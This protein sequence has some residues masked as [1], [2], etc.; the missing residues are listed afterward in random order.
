MTKTF[1]KYLLHSLLSLVFATG[2]FAGIPRDIFPRLRGNNVHSADVTPALIERM[3]AYRCNALRVNLDMDKGA[4]AGGDPLAPYQKSL[5]N[6]GSVFPACR[7]RG[8]QVILCLSGVPGRRLDVFWNQTADGQNY[9]S[10]IVEIWR[11]LAARY[12]DEP[13]LIGYDILNEPT[14]KSSE[15]DNW[16]KQTLPQSVAAIRESDASIWIVVEPGPWGLPS[17]FEQ[18]PTLDDAR[19]IYSF[20]HY[21]PHAYTHQGVSHVGNASAVDTRGW[22]SYPGD[23]PTFGD[24]TDVKHWNA[25]R[26]EE[27]MKPVI[28]FQKRNP[29]VRILVGEFGV[30][31]W[32]AGNAQWLKD[33][34]DLFEKLGWDW[35]FH[36]L[37]GWNGWDPSVAPDA[38]IDGSQGGGQETDRLAVLKEKWSANVPNTAADAPGTFSLKAAKALAWWET[39]EAVVFKPAKP[40][41][42]AELKALEGQITDGS[43][44]GLKT[45]S[46]S[47]EALLREGWV[48][49]PSEPGFYEI[50]FSWNRASGQKVELKDVFW[51]QAPNG[52]KARFERAAYS[53]A[54]VAPWDAAPKAIGEFGWQYH[55]NQSEIPLAKAVGF[56]FTMI[57]SIPWG[58]HFASLG[59]AIQPA[60]DVYRWDALDADVKALSE[61]G[62]E[63]GGQFCYTPIWASPYPER[64]NKINICV[65]EASA[66][67]PV[68]MDDFT[69]FIE[70]TIARYG[71]TIRTWEIWNEPNL[72]GASCFWSD[73][74]ENYLR[75]Q[76]A[77]Y[78][79]IKRLQPEARVWNGGIADTPSYREFLNR[80]LAGGGGA[81][82]DDLSLHG[83]NVDVEN[84]QAVEKAHQVPFKPVVNSEWHAF[85]IGSFADGKDLPSEEALSLRMMKSAL[86][87]I[88]QGVSMLVIF[89]MTDQVEKEVLPFARENQWFTHC[90]GLFRR[91]PRLEPRHPAVVMAQFLRVTG[92]EA[93]FVKEV[94]LGDD[95]TGIVLQTDHG[96][97]LAFWSEKGP[98]PLERAAIF[99]SGSSI[100]KDWEGK[101]LPIQGQ[102]ELASGKIYYLSAL[103]DTWRTAENADTLD[104]AERIQRQSADAPVASYATGKAEAKWI[105][106]NWKWTPLFADAPK[107]PI[108]AKARVSATEQGLEIEIEVKDAKHVQNEESQWWNGD[109]VQIGIDCEGRGRHGQNAEILAALKPGS[110]VFWKIKNA[111]SGADIPARRSLDNSPIQYGNCEIARK[112]G[113]TAYRL[114]LEWSELYPAV[115]VPGRPLRLSMVVNNNDGA[116]RQGYLEWGG[117]IGG[118]KDP[119]LYG[120]LLPERGASK[121]EEQQSHK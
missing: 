86:L 30:I 83:R 31:R 55:L 64:E 114:F 100:L 3:A 56:D 23:C 22:Y 11:A 69:R 88:K 85:L 29:G 4:E 42:P 10:S 104:P 1:L 61:A 49:H 110:T 15:A 53:V 106:Q 82:F 113:V 18:M 102:K 46:V 103:A 72:P 81:Y 105:D 41:V 97:L 37:G 20:H 107:V 44:K 65:R 9:R 38:P 40:E 62:F 19:V 94:R 21:M 80:V 8:I 96:P 13:A 58:A 26:L 32:A 91:A 98:A 33:S 5:A 79:T 12:K 39:G 27:S 24:G 60:R 117:G 34:I 115:Y 57:H 28:D 14:Y 68:N 75:L 35:T 70:K 54:V 95:A 63:I 74:P 7:A 111:D 2:V 66:Y 71:E 52:A 25:Q 116:G 17:G 78:E 48:W 90:A 77:G 119:S 108:S 47:R 87:Q 120:K 112:D 84:F 99:A 43:G 50:A 51:I 101:T 89:E 67:A 73:T 6:L 16:W 45:I 59:K 92:R 109:S 76:K 118:V 36:S 93:R 121:S